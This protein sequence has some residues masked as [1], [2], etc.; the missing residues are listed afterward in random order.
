M[1]LFTAGKIPMYC[2]GITHRLEK[3][4]DSEVKVVD[5]ALKIEPFNAQLAA[6]LDQDEYGFVKRTLFKMNDG[7]PTTDL[8]AVEFRTPGDRQQ[9]HC[10][11]SPDSPEASIMFDHV[12]VTRLRARCSKEATGWVFS[13]HVSFG[14]VDKTEL[15]AVNEWYTGMKWVRF[16]EAEPSF[17][18]QEANQDPNAEGPEPDGG[19]LVDEHR[20][21]AEIQATEDASRPT[22]RRGRKPKGKTNPEAER[23]AQ[24]EEG[25]KKAKAGK[26][27]KPRINPDVVAATAD[28]PARDDGADFDT[29]H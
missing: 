11:A 18:F 17:A 24:R 26:V 16:E 20:E 2:E 1:Q 15:E 13:V 6:A 28:A 12:K 5:L 14:P 29:T 10:Y 4:K 23:K 22:A 9:L 3:R 8:R 27:R 25:V 19:G 21:L 7:D